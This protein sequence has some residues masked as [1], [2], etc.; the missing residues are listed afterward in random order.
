MN[1]FTIILLLSI[2]S[3]FCI[4]SNSLAKGIHDTIPVKHSTDA[5]LDDWDPSSFDLHEPSG[6]KMAIENDTEKLFV[7]IYVTKREV[8]KVLALAGMRLLIDIKGKKKEA[9]YL[10]F[11]LQ[12]EPQTAALAIAEMGNNE[13]GSPDQLSK[14][15]ILLKKNGFKNQLQENEIQAIT[16]TSDIQVSFGWDE[17]TVLYIEYEVPFKSLTDYASLKN[18][19]ITVGFKINALEVPPPEPK[20]VITTTKTVAVPAG[21]ISPSNFRGSTNR[22]FSKAVTTKTL[23]QQQSFWMKRLIK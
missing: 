12:K 3:F 22:D 13:N 18:K 1:R 2:C 9:T 10:E 5:I 4:A 17:K 21:S 11:P 6:I 16:S 23:A 15:M 14:H 19:E 7:A 20:Q 8:Q